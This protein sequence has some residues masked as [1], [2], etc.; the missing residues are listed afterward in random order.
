MD[1]FH[2][3]PFR[4]VSGGDLIAQI[5]RHSFGVTEYQQYDFQPDPGISESELPST[6]FSH[7]N[8][9]RIA[10]LRYTVRSLTTSNDFHAR[11]TR[12]ILWSDRIGR[13]DKICNAVSAGSR[14]NIKQLV[15]PVV[16]IGRDPLQ[17]WLQKL[18]WTGVKVPSHTNRLSCYIWRTSLTNIITKQ[19]SVQ[20]F[21]VQEK[22]FF[23]PQASETKNEGL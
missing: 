7:V 17:R 1:L 5:S 20:S 4:S 16:T 22:P 8:R 9:W 18:Q 12:A 11:D 2:A 19:T 15:K 6:S 10:A 13:Y 14:C 3:N 23:A 21:D